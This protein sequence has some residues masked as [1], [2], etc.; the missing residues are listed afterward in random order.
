MM[1]K[2]MKGDFSFYR[3]RKHVRFLCCRSLLS[4][5]DSYFFMDFMTSELKQIPIL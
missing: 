1:N 5:L 4:L 2:Q 3:N